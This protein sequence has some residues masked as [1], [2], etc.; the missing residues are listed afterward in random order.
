MTKIR[1]FAAPTNASADIN[2]RSSNPTL[3]ET[4]NHFPRFLAATLFATSLV[5]AFGVQANDMTNAPGATAAVEM[6]HG[7]VKS[8]DKDG[9]KLT[10]KHGELK[11]LGMPGMTMVFRV[12]DP[13]MLGQVNAG[14]K[15]DFMAEKVNGAL[16][17]TMLAP[18][19]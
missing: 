3:K 19:H 8:I 6:S 4:M 11:N 10:I 15:I 12:K 16:T 13:A 2:P 18:S 1:R 9:G 17:V 14:D 5:T 7:E